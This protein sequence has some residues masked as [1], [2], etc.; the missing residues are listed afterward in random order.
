ML[1]P[2]QAETR[3]RGLARPGPA[4][5]RYARPVRDPGGG[6]A[7]AR[8]VRRGRAEY[9]RHGPSAIWKKGIASRGRRGAKACLPDESIFPRASCGEKSVHPVFIGRSIGAD[10]CPQRDARKQNRD[11]DRVTNGRETESLN[12]RKYPGQPSAMSARNSNGSNHNDPPRAWRQMKNPQAYGKS[13]G[14]AGAGGSERNL[15]QTGA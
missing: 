5:P 14:R 10:N 2:G 12:I 13:R 7:D 8:G 9:V 15:N 4:P 1:T 6:Q 3:R 11:R